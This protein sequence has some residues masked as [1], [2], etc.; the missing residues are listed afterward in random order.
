[1]GLGSGGEDNGVDCES[2][3]Y[4]SSDGKEGPTDN[5]GTNLWHAKYLI[6]LRKGGPV[7]P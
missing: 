5:P 3:M 2:L 4:R 6:V 1:M 7:F